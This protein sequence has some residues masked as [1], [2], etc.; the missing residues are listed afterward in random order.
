MR[1]CHVASKKGVSAF[2]NAKGLFYKTLLKKWDESFYKNSL[3]IEKSL[4]I[5]KIS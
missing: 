4:K 1:A 2:I 3:K 5:F